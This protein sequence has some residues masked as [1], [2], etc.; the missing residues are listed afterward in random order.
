MFD[1]PEPIYVQ[2]AD[3]IRAD[4]ISGR[5]AAGD[6]VM[7]T[8]QYATTYRINPA[9]AAK[10]FTELV[11]EGILYKQRGVGMFVAEGAPQRLRAQ[12]REAFFTDW[13]DPVLRE[14]RMLG[15]DTADLLAYIQKGGRL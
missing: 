8:T 10:A 9:T 6:Q 1:G 3:Q 12:R 11:A 5:L 15:I 4:I 13:M 7:S 2:I 14:A